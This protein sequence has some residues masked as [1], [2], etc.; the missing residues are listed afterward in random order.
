VSK[1]V[2]DSFLRLWMARLL[3]GLWQEGSAYLDKGQTD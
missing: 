3:K 2:D 1:L